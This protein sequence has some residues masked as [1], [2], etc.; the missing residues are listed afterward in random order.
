MSVT[1]IATNTG[2]NQNNL[3]DIIIK[4]CVPFANCISDINN[5]QIG[6]AKDRVMPMYNLIEYIDN[7]S[8]TSGSL[9]Q[10]Y[11]D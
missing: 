2:A 7:Y 6:N 3:K 10:Y 11:R 5:K 9:Y 4:N 8:K 1:I